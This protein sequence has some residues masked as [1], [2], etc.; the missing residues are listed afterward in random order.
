MLAKRN[1]RVG[2]L[3]QPPKSKIASPIRTS[4]LHTPPKPEIFQIKSIRI[5][6]A[7]KIQ[8]LQIIF[9]IDLN[10]RSKM[11]LDIWKIFLRHF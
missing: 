7:S 1:I 6:S 10:L 4:V 2:V 3:H 9:R 5:A 11:K 8:N